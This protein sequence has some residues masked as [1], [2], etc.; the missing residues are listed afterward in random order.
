[1][2]VTQFSIYE[3]GFRGALPHMTMRA[4]TSF[5]I[6]KNAFRGALP[7]IDIQAVTEFWI[8]LIFHGSASRGQHPSNAGSD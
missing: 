3:N 8:F 6:H 7:R 2:A 4:V 1:M 5:E